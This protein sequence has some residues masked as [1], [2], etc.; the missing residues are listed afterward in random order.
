MTTQ[1]D[2]FDQ[3][4]H[5]MVRNPDHS[6][7][8][9]AAERVATKRSL[10]QSSVLTAFRTYGPMTDEQLER[11]P[12]FSRFASGTVRKRRTELCQQGFIEAYGTAVNSRKSSV[13]IWRHK[14]L[15]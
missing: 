15:C 10:L 5:G 1:P 13:K 7:S 4:I 14:Y 9:T 11:L 8:I 6:T 3:P 12:E 2:L